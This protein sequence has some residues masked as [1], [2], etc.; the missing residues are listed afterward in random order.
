MILSYVLYFVLGFLEASIAMFFY[1]FG[2]KNFDALCA[3]TDWFRGFIWLIIVCTLIENV[4][5]NKPLGYAYITGASFGTY[6]GLKIEVVMEKY[7]LKIKNKGRRKKRFF[8]QN[9]KKQ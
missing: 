4:H 9:E 7:I 2:Q 5:T 6:F 3:L 8:L 1:K